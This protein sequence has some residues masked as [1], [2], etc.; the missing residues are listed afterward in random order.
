MQSAQVLSITN[1]MD[2]SNVPLQSGSTIDSKT[3]Q[4][5][6]KLFSLYTAINNLAYLAK[7]AQS[8]TATWRARHKSACCGN[9]V[10]PWR[11]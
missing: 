5:N 3:E 10:T 6:Q 8:S 9:C 2:T 11:Y 1:F 4:D 7:M